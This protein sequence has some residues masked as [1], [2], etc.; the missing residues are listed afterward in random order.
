[1]IFISIII[2]IISEK[3]N[4][5]QIPYDIETEEFDIDNFIN[6]EYPVP[7]AFFDRSK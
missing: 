2:K 5:S 4:C 3:L 6:D 1:M 7:S